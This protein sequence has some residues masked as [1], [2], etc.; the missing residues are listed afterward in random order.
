M[1]MMF[2]CTVS[3]LK[4]DGSVVGWGD[5]VY[6]Q[7]TVP[8]P[9]S[10]FT[11]IDA[12]GYHGLGLKTDGSVICW[13][14]NYFNQCNVPAQNTDFVAVAAGQKRIILTRDRRLLYAKSV[15]H[16]YWVRA[17]IPLQQ[18]TEVVRRFDLSAQIKP[19][20]RCTRC[21]GVIESVAKRAVLHLLHYRL[22][23]ELNGD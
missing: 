23:Q 2:S 8:S 19:F 10:D 22:L 20:Y 17:V 9:N 4:T 21:N 16:G 5:N 11:A 12:G 15:T 3:F 18:L 7:C 1:A 6:G 14:Y 13:G